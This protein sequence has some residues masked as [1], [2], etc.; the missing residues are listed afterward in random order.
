MAKKDKFLKIIV[1][2][3][4]FKPFRGKVCECVCV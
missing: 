4:L 1:L 2:L 3:V